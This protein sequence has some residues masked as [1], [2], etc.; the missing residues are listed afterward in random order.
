[1]KHQWKWKPHKK[2]LSTLALFGNPLW[3]ERNRWTEEKKNGR[4]GNKTSFWDRQ[5]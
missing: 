5:F 4:E 2:F 3:K 1:M